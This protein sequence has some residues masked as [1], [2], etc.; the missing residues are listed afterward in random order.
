MNQGVRQ[1]IL[2]FG[3]I[4]LSLTLVLGSLVLSMIEGG[5]GLALATQPDLIATA[6]KQAS[7]TPSPVVTL[8]PGEPTY[9]PQ[10]SLTN[11][12]VP[13]PTP[14]CPLPE[15]WSQI[16]VQVG[17]SMESLAAGY[18]TTAQVLMQANCLNSNQ[19]MPGMVLYVPPIVPAEQVVAPTSVPTT[20]CGPPRNWVQIVIQPGDTLYELGKKYGVTVGELQAANCLGSS[21]DIKAGQKLY[22]PYVP[23]ATATRTRTPTVQLTATLTLVP[24]IIHTATFTFTPSLTPT[25][26]PSPTETL[27]PTV[28]PTS[29]ETPTP[30]NT[31]TPSDTPTPTDIVITLSPGQ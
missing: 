10:P 28:T 7:Q 27:T 24:T 13:T 26:T 11:T 21:I 9:T 4:A 6:L 2:A 1:F 3:A 17:D 19:V 31:P 14:G 23:T 25:M 8:E 5:F 30:T 12:L 22:V 16:S 29:T 15:G 20:R 18:G